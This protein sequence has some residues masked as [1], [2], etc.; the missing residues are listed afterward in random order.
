MKFLD[1]YVLKICHLFLKSKDLTMKK[2][3]NNQLPN[4]PKIYMT[5]SQS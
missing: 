4:T 2:K 5:L 3:L 1:I